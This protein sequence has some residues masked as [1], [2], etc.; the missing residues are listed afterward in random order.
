M[1]ER[2]IELR[3]PYVDLATFANT[4]TARASHAQALALLVSDAA[5]GHP[6]QR[7]VVD[8]TTGGTFHVM[9]ARGVARWILVRLAVAHDGT[10]TGTDRVNRVTPSDGD[11]HDHQRRQP[12]SDGLKADTDM[13]PPV[14]V[15]TGRLDVLATRA[16]VIDLAAFETGG[17][18]LS[19]NRW[20]LSFDVTRSGSNVYCESLTVEELPR[21]VI[22]DADDY[23]ALPE[24]YLQR[25]T[26]ADSATVQR[27]G[28]T[29]EYGIT[30]G[31][32][33]YHQLVRDEADP[34]SI[35]STSIAPWPGDEESSG[36]GR[37]YAC[38]ART[39]R[40]ATDPQIAFRVR[41]RI[42]G[43]SGSD[44]GEVTLSWP[45]GSASL[46]L[47]D[48]SGS[49]AEAEGTATLDATTPEQQITWK[50]RVDAGTCSRDLRPHRLR[51]P[52][53]TS[54]PDITDHRLRSGHG[55]AQ[56]RPSCPPL[57]TPTAPSSALL[58]ADCMH[59]VRVS[60]MSSRLHHAS[61]RAP[62]RCSTWEASWRSKRCRRCGQHPRRQGRGNGRA[63]PDPRG[64]RAH[65]LPRGGGAARPGP[66][67]HDDAAHRPKGGVTW[68]RSN[69]EAAALRSTSS[70]SSTHSSQSCPRA[71]CSAGQAA[72]R[73]ASAATTPPRCARCWGSATRSP[74]C[75]SPPARCSICALK[76]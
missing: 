2:A 70:R 15:A 6:R 50:G 1:T 58:S 37:K 10:Y 65:D 44:E 73:S 9:L 48:I 75:R 69:R 57:P 26:I 30:H 55:P 3:T 47:T 18:S 25:G 14:V 59:Q 74:N 60:D 22:D 61:S 54:S 39:M 5:G 49:W 36:V 41:Y 16:W 8:R 67:R 62:T 38:R 53:L 76:S 51:R 64:G 46:A 72:R 56:E 17:T 21:F 28:D 42:I 35:V 19:G 7:A 33:T 11:H 27:L 24:L 31:W 40:G 66:H 23:G 20:T 71:R 68:A 4:L 63:G 32:R 43:A 12:S 52:C 29:V 34:W 13:A 45:T